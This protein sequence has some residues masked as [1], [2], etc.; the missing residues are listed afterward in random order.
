MDTTEAYE[1]LKGHSNRRFLDPRSWYLTGTSGPKFRPWAM[2]IGWSSYHSLQNCCTSGQPI[3]RLGEWL[4]V[5][6][7][8]EL[9]RDPQSIGAVN[10]REWRRGYD[11]ITKI[12][13]ELSVEMTRIAAEGQSVWERARP[14]NDWPHL[15][16]TS[17]V[18]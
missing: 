17:N 11:R 10:I 4:A 12:P 5:V 15:C 1:A 18:S 14:E 8:S 13:E 16:L 3:P 9:T 2:P 7:G 6:E